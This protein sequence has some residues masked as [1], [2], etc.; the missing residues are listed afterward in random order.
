MEKA[1]QR[2]GQRLSTAARTRAQGAACAEPGHDKMNIEVPLRTS[3][4]LERVSRHGD[5]RIRRVSECLIILREV[6]NLVVSGENE[7]LA[8]YDLSMTKLNFLLL[9]R[10]AP[11]CRMSM[12]DLGK[13]L[14]I[15]GGSITK[16]VDSLEST[17]TVRRM[18]MRDDRRVVLV[19]LTEQGR[20][21]FDDV[22]E[23]HNRHWDAVWAG[24]SDDDLAEL[25]ARLEAV[26]QIYA[27]R[28]SSAETGE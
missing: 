27:E 28:P 13:D 4:L 24:I 23:E 25:I 15:T 16:L 14:T 11:D 26:G 9:L 20:R 17:G 2:P 7:W 5:S 8:K 22:T 19:E 3:R 18:Q 6:Y 21:L 12:T 10:W 1:N